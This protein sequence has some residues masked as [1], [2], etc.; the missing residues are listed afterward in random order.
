MFFKPAYR[1]F[2]IGSLCTI[3]VAGSLLSQTP[4]EPRFFS[5][6]LYPEL[7]KA[8][9]NG[10]HADDGVAS[11]TRLHFPAE[12]ASDEDIEAFGTRLASLVDRKNP[13]RSLLV[14]K[15]TNRLEHTG[16][17]R[18]LPGS[19]EERLLQLWVR[20]LA[21]SSIV[22][23]SQSSLSG[24][25]GPEVQPVFMSRLTHSQYNNTVRD[26]LGDET[27]PADQFPQEDYV[28]GFKNQSEVQSIPLLL[29]E[30]YSAAAEK[31]ARSAF[32]SGQ[33]KKIVPCQP[34]S[35]G[36]AACRSQFIGHFGRRA[37]RRPLTASEL[38]RYNAL[39]IRESR[40]TGKFFSG[41][42][43]VVETMLQSPNFLFRMERGPA[44]KW[45]NYEIASRLSYFLW[46][47]MPD[48]PLFSS[49]A[50]RELGTTAGVE[51]AA[52][53]MLQHPQARQALNEFVSQWLRFDR[54]LNVVRDRR[55]FQQFNSGLAVAMTEETRRLAAHLAWNN[56]NFMEIYTARYGFL[57]TELAALYGFP[58]P[59]E[60]F[61]MVRFPAVSDRAGLLG[62]AT[63]LTL[64]S[65]PGE[66]S[67]TE[68]GLFI[69]EHFLCQKVPPPPPGV[70]ASLPPL[71]ENK[72]MTSRERL[73]V[74]LSNESCASCHRLIDPIGFG[75]EKFDAI[76]RKRE[77]LALTFFAARG[78]T[79]R[80]PT[81]VE[82]ELD[83]K[84]RISGIPDS[85]FSTPAELGQV[86]ASNAECQKCVV[87]QVFRYAM[88]RLETPS[89]RAVIDKGFDDFKRSQFK[90]QQLIISLVTSK[91]FRETPRYD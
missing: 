7:Q 85:D 22:D 16:G 74:H 31:L 88:G 3:L 86:L 84:G 61:G 14:T 78:E 51:Q 75:L 34:A 36:G 28:R 50:A 53:R 19:K 47:S 38:Q 54:V 41:A 52:R 87:R 25:T 9:C 45:A 71:S 60:Q 27:R 6:L 49:A 91:A 68:R 69:R 29:A 73:Q 82:L 5:K 83:T 11:A 21:A 72:P 2:T 44:A 63:F 1:V 40:R 57:S 79:D 80:K 58:A 42:E 62:Q 67:P 89:D 13:E 39:F 64:T 70:S 23:D 76:G 37:F 8:G 30:A 90:F 81:K 65:K 46:D 59:A 24:V 17:Q 10:C 55:L 66:T 77:K 32:R 12:S 15:P 43:L 48:E 35:F 33:W 20:H 56:Q 26:L 18:I 4:D